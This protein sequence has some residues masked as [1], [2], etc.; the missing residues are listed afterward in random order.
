MFCSRTTRRYR[1]ATGRL[2][3]RSRR[4]T[5][6]DP[7][8][9]QPIRNEYDQAGRLIAHTDAN[10]NRVVYTH[11]IGTGDE[12]VQDRLGGVVLPG[13]F[14]CGGVECVDDATSCDEHCAY[15]YVWKEVKQVTDSILAHRTLADVTQRR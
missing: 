10:G 6:A 1:R 13:G 5:I 8:G 2:A 3:T 14:A 9:I 4:V 12:S 11:A 15:C 7:R